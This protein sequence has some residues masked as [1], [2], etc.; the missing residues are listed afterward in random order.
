MEAISVLVLCHTMIAHEQ[1]LLVLFILFD[2][3]ARM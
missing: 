2:V 1:S 3:I